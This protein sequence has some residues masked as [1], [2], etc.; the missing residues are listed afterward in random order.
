MASLAEQAL[1]QC[2]TTKVVLSGYSQGGLVTHY[3]VQQ[4][5]L[6]AAD[7]SAIV[8]F[9]DPGEPVSVFEK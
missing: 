2:P 7:V 1:K 3:A 6:P 9:G 8:A 5:G 4:G